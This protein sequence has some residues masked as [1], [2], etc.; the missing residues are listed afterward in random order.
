[1]T[2]AGFTRRD[3]L[4]QSVRVA[5]AAIAVNAWPRAAATLFASPF[6]GLPQ[7][8]DSAA[9]MRQQMGAIPI[10]TTPLADQLT[11]LSGPGGNVVVLNGPDGKV[12]VD[13]F[14]RNVW[15]K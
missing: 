8:P 9:A 4:R 12:V 14:V 1:T 6:D 7:A 13:T 2:A 5:G 15:D 11:M 3:L 10:T